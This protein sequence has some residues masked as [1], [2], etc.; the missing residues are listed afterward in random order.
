M[1][2]RGL[3]IGAG[4]WATGEEKTAQPA[5]LSMQVSDSHGERLLHWIV[6][7]CALIYSF[8]LA[9]KDIGRLHLS[10]LEYLRQTSCTVFCM[11]PRF[12]Y[13]LSQYSIADLLWHNGN[14]SAKKGI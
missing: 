2:R 10:L 9:G 11:W 4:G 7:F 14:K 13:P 12:S 6:G 8:A 5:L 3:G 1:G